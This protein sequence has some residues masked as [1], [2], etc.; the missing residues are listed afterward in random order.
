MASFWMK[1]GI[2][3]VGRSTM[4]W[5]LV[6]VIAVGGL[7]AMTKAVSAEQP[8]FGRRG[9]RGGRHAAGMVMGLRQL[10]LTDAQREA[11]RAVMEAHR[12]ESTAIRER[13]APLR[14]ALR[15]A[16]MAEVIDEALVRHYTVQLADVQA[17][18]TIASAK[19]RAEIF[20]LL[21]PEQQARAQE[22]RAERE[23]RMEERR[24][25]WQNR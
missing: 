23:R 14:A 24:A 9:P 2:S 12:S 6:G 4:A 21:T 18:M 11:V 13:S 17:D 7:A 1:K 22:L 16:T 19:L 25:R 15:E 5:G 20:Q 10:D 8:G 3:T